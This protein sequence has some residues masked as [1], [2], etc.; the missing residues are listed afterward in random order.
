MNKCIHCES[1]S[2]DNV[3]GICVLNVRFIGL[4][5][6]RC[7]KCVNNCKIFTMAAHTGMHFV[8]IYLVTA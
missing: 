6:M 5:V 8:L 2:Y 3:C 4:I 1:I 7:K